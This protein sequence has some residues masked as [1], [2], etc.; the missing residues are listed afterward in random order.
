MREIAAILDSCIEQFEAVNIEL[1]NADLPQLARRA[2]AIL[3][4][5]EWLRISL[6]E[7]YET[8]SERS[9]ESLPS[10]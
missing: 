4:L 9:Q 5:T 3:I 2:N 10:G 7:W 6:D 1:N 8:S